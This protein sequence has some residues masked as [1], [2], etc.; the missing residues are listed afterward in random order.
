MRRICIGVVI[1]ALVCATTSGATHSALSA[2]S[3]AAGPAIHIE[4][5]ERS[6]S[7]NGLA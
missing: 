4:D 6:M 3:V 5:V 2:A 1:G 7:Q